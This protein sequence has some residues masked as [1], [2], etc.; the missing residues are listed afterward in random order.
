MNQSADGPEEPT[1]E[2][3]SIERLLSHGRR[4]LD[5]QE[6]IRSTR[7]FRRWALSTWAITGL[8]V[9]TFAL[10]NI[11]L[12]GRVDLARTNV[13]LIPIALVLL[14]CTIGFR[15]NADS[16]NWTASYVSSRRLD[17]EIAQ[18]RRRLYAAKLSPSEST[19]RH[20][21]REETPAT[22][23]ELRSGQ[24][25]YRRVHNI[26][27]SLIIVGS[28]ASS[29][30]AGLAEIQGIQKTILV[31]VTFSVG[32]ASGFTGYFKFRERGFY[33]QQT[34]DS[35][36]GELSSLQLGVAQYKHIQEPET[37]LAEFAERVELLKSE[38]RK[39]E[40]QL[41]QPSQKLEG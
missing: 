25:Y 16:R 24:R 35:I 19:L 2:E 31:C 30:I 14:I 7:I 27:Q 10:V 6:D 40:Q 22:V 1:A 4:I 9:P 15:Y 26:L 13:A 32:L 23:A 34:A 36:E 5:I 28:L 20:L 3:A 18:E 17:L 29:T 37:A 38:Q 39:R 21:Y 11:A 33:L 41:D 8:F 12:W